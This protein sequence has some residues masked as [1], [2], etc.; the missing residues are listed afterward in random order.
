[1]SYTLRDGHPATTDRGTARLPIEG[2]RAVADRSD[3]L[4]LVGYRSPTPAERRAVA[5]AP[6]SLAV[7][8]RGPVALVLLEFGTPADAGYV[9]C[10]APLSVLDPDADPAPFLD[11][12]R[13]GVSVR[14][15]LC[16]IA[17]SRVR[18]TRTLHA[19]PDVASVLRTSG[20][21]QRAAFESDAGV[22]AASL[23]LMRST[24]FAALLLSASHQTLL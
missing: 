23:H 6:A 24:T 15:A 12:E 9:S 14:V 4:V 20:H 2:A 7:L 8:A 21:T 3:L 10:A 17:S 13:G 18:A 5:S 22:Q 16:D 19:P 11:A 1:M